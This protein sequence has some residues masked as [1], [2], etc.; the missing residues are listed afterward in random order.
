MQI[1]IIFPDLFILYNIPLY[2]NI[3]LCKIK[4]D[5]NFPSTCCKGKKPTKKK[6]TYKI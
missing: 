5:T 3:Y 2:T 1:V 4:Y 6:I